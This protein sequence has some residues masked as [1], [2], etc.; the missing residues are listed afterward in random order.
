MKNLKHWKRDEKQSGT[1]NYDLITR[2]KD[3]VSVHI[4]E[5]WCADD[6]GNLLI[7]FV[8]FTDR[9]KIEETI[10]IPKAAFKELI[11]IQKTAKVTRQK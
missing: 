8:I 7:D 2:D 5:S 4:T 10:Y 3:S 1:I 9:G 6:T 11:K